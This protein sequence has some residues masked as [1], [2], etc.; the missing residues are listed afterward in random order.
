MPSVLVV[1]DD[2]DILALLRGWLEDEGFDVTVATGA[3]EGSEAL[4]RAPFDVVVLDL[5]LPDA[6][7]LDAIKLF[8]ACAPTVPLIAISGH[9]FVEHPFPD[10]F[11]KLA[12]DMGAARCLPKPL[13]ETALLREIRTLLA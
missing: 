8:R 11:R 3:A 10:Q 2:L 13:T 5:F 1:D 7:G 6:S 9:V 12:L 4:A